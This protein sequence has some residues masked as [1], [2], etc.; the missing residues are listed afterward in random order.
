MKMENMALLLMITGS[1]FSY[2]M[3]RLFIWA[4]SL[5]EK[6]AIEAEEKAAQEGGNCF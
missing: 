3:V 2:F 1:F 5:L 4:D 6:E